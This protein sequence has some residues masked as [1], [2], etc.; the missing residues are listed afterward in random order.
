MAKGQEAEE[1]RE[2][3]FLFWIVNGILFTLV[4]YYATRLVWIALRGDL[5]LLIAEYALTLALRLYPEGEGKVLICR[6][7]LDAA[8]LSFSTSNG[9]L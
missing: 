6:A 9:V 8:V 7:I 5:R 2:V 4:A 3:I 1:R